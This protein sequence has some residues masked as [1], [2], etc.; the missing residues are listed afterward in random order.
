MR[1]EKPWGFEVDLGIF[2]GTHVKLIR[3]RKGERT[4]YHYHKKKHERLTL[5]SGT[6]IIEYGGFF[7]ENRDE[8]YLIPYQHFRVVKTENHRIRALTDTLILELA[9]GKDISYR[10]EDDYGRV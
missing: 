4:S 3:I 1:T 2:N 5:L 7:E 9:D 6:A 8:D 10:L